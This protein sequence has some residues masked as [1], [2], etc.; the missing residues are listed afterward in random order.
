[1]DKL[2]PHLNIPLSEFIKEELRVRGWS[3]KKFI[4]VLGSTK[5]EVNLMFSNKERITKNITKLLSKVFG[6]SEQYWIN[7]DYNYHGKG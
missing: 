7:L 1:M 4:E 6:Q 2:K 3:R 5:K